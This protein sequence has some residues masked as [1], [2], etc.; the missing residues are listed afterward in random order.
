MFDAYHG[1]NGDAQFPAIWS[2]DSSVHQ[3]MASEPNA[4][5]APKPGRDHRPVWSQAGTL[6][7]TRDVRYNSQPIMAVRTDIRTLGVRAWHTL[8]MHEDDPMIKSRSEIALALWC[9]STL[10]MLLHANH[11]NSAQEGRGQGNKGMLESLTTMDV[12]KLRSWQL[13]EA[14][15]IWRDFERR[16]FQPF[17]QCAVDPAR[18]QLD[19]RIVR[20]MLGLGDGAI[21]S[22]ARLRTLLAGDPSIH[23][24]KRPELP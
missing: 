8:S 12:G 9:N 6:Q 14:Q 19:E 15:A 21:A 10:G 3:S 18:I 20:D 7:I 17:H 5:L 1:R 13:D 23:G 24:S 2:L 4:W 16:K 22:V 11:S